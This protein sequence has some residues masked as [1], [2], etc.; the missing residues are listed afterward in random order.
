MN[1]EPKHEPEQYTTNEHVALHK[2]VDDV[3]KHCDPDEVAALQDGLARA[4]HLESE[5]P[6]SREIRNTHVDEFRLPHAIAEA[7]HRIATGEELPEE[8]RLVRGEWGPSWPEGF[9]PSGQSGDDK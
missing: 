1:P 6:W 8:Q 3:T 9:V 4:V 7:G 5:Y 2:V